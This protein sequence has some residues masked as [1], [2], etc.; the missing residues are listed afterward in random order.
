MLDWESRIINRG[1]TDVMTSSRRRLEQI[2][3]EVERL[4]DTGKWNLGQFRRLYVAALE[5]CGG[6]YTPML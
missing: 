5:A 2:A 4:D 3:A 6:G 1:W